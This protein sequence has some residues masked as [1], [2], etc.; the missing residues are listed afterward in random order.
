MAWVGYNT[1]TG[2]RSVGGKWVSVSNRYLGLQFKIQGE[3]HYGWARLSVTVKGK[4]VTAV[5]TGY[6]YETVAGRRLRAGQEVEADIAGL[7]Q[8]PTDSGLLGMF[9]L[10]A[11]GIALWRR[12]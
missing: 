12:P 3:T 10:G 2:S 7:W 5:L 11:P 8:G 1:T 4:T 9:A 6:A